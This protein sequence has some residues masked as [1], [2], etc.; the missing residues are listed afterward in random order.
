LSATIELQIIG[1]QF[2][3]IVVV[4]YA[5]KICLFWRGR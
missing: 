2:D 5:V 1:G 3:V 4:F